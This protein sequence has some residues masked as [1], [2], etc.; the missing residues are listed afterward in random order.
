MISTINLI[1]WK[2]FDFDKIFISKRGKRFVK[3]N[4]TEGDI[5]YI[6]SSKRN[7][8]IDNFVSP[9]KFMKIYK[10][11][12]TLNN[13]GSVG[14]CFYH[15]Y[16][17]IC[18][19]HV[20]VISIRD[21]K[22]VLNPYL[23]LFLKPI[24]ESMKYKYNFAREI[25]DTRIK[26]EK[27]RLPQDK[28]GNPDWRYMENYIKNL[29]KSIFYDREVKKII[30]KN[31]NILEWKDFE[32]GNL[33]VVKSGEDKPKEFDSKHK[34]GILLNSVENLITN[35]GVN[36]KVLYGGKNKFRNFISVVS[37]GAG[38][39]AFYQEDLGATFTRV[40]ALIPKEGTLLNKYTA[41]FLITILKLEKFRYSYGRVL[42]DN[43]L[44]T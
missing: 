30:I 31:L 38:G 21:K 18:S 6:S 23:A 9:P 12:L 35:N 17:I 40:K 25:S 33:F 44:K 4:Q 41:L 39:H 11:V 13:S 22:I 34:Q 10:N 26:K 14:Y 7:N 8:A 32:V 16:S 36:G 43:R 20:T 15:K 2:E 42:D 1:N 27:I 19:D 28:E 29:S 5:A 37:I 3:L 24:I